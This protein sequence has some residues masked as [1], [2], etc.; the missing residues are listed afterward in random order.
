MADQSKN[1]IYN[2]SIYYLD[3]QFYIT[4][5]VRMPPMGMRTQVLPLY[6]VPDINREKF[7]E[8]IEAAKLQSDL[9]FYYDHI[10]PN[11]EEWD[12][13]NEKVWNTAKK[14]WDIIWRDDGNVSINPAEPYVKHKNGVEWI[15]IKDAKKVLS[16]PVSALDIAEEIVKQ[17]KA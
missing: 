2:I 5:L 4:P 3:N 14:N 10:K 1:F 11:R 15:F 13:D 9:R 7:A 8:A 17:I 16:T 6:I 12:G